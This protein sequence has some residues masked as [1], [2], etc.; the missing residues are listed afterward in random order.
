MLIVTNPSPRTCNQSRLIAV[1]LFH[2]KKHYK[3]GIWSKKVE[4]PGKGVEKSHK[5]DKELN[6]SA[7]KKVILIFLSDDLFDGQ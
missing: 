4:Q 5:Q 3:T 1:L 6:L 2:L 7:S